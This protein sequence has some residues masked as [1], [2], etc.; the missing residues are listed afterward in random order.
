M[1]L[2]RVG[3][4][5]SP[6]PEQPDILWLL[7]RVRTDQLPDALQGIWARLECRDQVDEGLRP[8]RVKP[9][10]KSSFEGK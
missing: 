1:N 4:G 7:Q 3:G 8:R 9:S 6:E 10:R 5:S 2:W